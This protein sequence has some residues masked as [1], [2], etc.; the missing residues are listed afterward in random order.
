LSSVGTSQYTKMF[1]GS[2]SQDI[3]HQQA[4]CSRLEAPNHSSFNQFAPKL[5]PQPTPLSNMN[6]IPTAI[7]NFL[8]KVPFWHLSVRPGAFSKPHANAY[9]DIKYELP[10]YSRSKLPRSSL[11]KSHFRHLSVRPGVFSKA[12]AKAY[13]AVKYERPIYRRSKVLSHCPVQVLLV[14]TTIRGLPNDNGNCRALFRYG[15]S[16]TTPETTERS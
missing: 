14:V 1:L 11:A 6:L 10:T 9:Q 5:M 4:L 2:L 12:D 7:Q 3:P 15:D 13:P 16:R 8:V